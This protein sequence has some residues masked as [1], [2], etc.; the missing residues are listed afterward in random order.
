M[1]LFNRTF[2]LVAIATGIV[3]CGGNETHNEKNAVTTE[4]AA[5]ETQV[6]D[7]TVDGMVCAMGCAATIQ[8]EVADIDGVSVSEVDYADE[9][10]HFEF[11]PAITSEEEI[12]AKIATIADGQ[13]ILSTWE[14]KEVEVTEDSEDIEVDVQQEQQSLVQVSLP[15]LKIPN[16]FTLLLNQL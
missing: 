16:L 7:Y 13:Y 14:D 3:A 4:V 1:I 10:A 5:L 15:N 2:I 6:L 8:H 11:D 12:K 9:K